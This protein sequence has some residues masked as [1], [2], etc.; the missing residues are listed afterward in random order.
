M[1]LQEY[2]VIRLSVG[3]AVQVADGPQVPQRVAGR[4][5]LG[6]GHACGDAHGI[7]VVH[8][9]DGIAHLRV[10]KAVLGAVLVVVDFRLG[11][12]VGRIARPLAREAD[13]LA[14]H[15]VGIGG[16]VVIEDGADDAGAGFV[17]GA[18]AA[19]L[20]GGVLGQVDFGWELPLVFRAQDVDFALIAQ[21]G[22]G[23]CR[24]FGHMER[25]GRHVEAVLPV[26]GVAFA[27]PL[28]ANFAVDQQIRLFQG[29]GFGEAFPLAE[30][31]HSEVHQ[32]VTAAL[33]DLGIAEGVGAAR[34]DD[35]GHI[36][37]PE[38][39]RSS[40]GDARPGTS[41]RPWPA[42]RSSGPRGCPRARP[43]PR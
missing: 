25:R 17:H 38:F 6:M 7:A 27:V 39:Q 15:Q 22:E 26:F 40:P 36:M 29:L 3:A 12:V 19:E 16:V 1:L 23:D 41:S 43:C 42:P 9:V 13:H 4:R 11:M 32:H 8:L 34:S 28:E 24:G 21:A 18:R 5:A 37:P 30:P 20:V 35:V 14:Q 31:Q 33:C 2:G 10:A